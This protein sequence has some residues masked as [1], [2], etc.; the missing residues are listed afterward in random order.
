MAFRRSV[1][2]VALAVLVVLVAMNPMNNVLAGAQFGR[3]G[4]PYTPEK[5]AKDLK[6]VL[7]NWTW[8]MGMLRGVSE[9]EIV[10]TLE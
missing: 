8:H 6:A 5:G 7:S 10:T 4:A 1:A 3:G 2:T 9:P